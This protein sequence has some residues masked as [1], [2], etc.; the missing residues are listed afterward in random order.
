MAETRVTRGSPFC[1]GFGFVDIHVQ[2][3]TNYLDFTSFPFCRES[4]A[5]MQNQKHGPRAT[6][7]PLQIRDMGQGPAK[8]LTH[9]NMVPFRF[10]GCFEG[11]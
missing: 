3:N 1:R 5:T 10:R 8:P 9:L 2:I 11:S 6:E 4:R 7:E